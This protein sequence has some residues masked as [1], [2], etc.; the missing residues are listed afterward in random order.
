[1][2][3]R[4]GINGDGYFRARHTSLGILDADLPRLKGYRAGPDINL[5]QEDKGLQFLAQQIANAAQELY[6]MPTQGNC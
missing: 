2:N 1:M 4:I 5:R 6:D 3:I